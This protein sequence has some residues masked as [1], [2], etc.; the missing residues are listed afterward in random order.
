MLG[1]VAGRVA[2]ALAGAETWATQRPRS[3]WV[4]ALGLV[5]LLV[6]LETAYWPLHDF[7]GAFW[8][9]EDRGLDIELG[10][11]H[12]ATAGWKELVGFWRGRMLHGHGYFRPLSSW[13]FVAEYRLF[14]VQDRFWTTFSILFH[15]SVALLL[16]WAVAGMV[17]GSRLRRLSVGVLA[18]LL[19]G[20]PGC[21]DRGVQSWVIGWWPAQPE[22]L[23]LLFG[24]LVLGATA[25]FV[26]TGAAG[27]AW[28]AP[29]A[30]FLAVTSKEM[31]YVAGLGACLLLLRHPRRWGLLAALSGLGI[32]LFLYRNAVLGDIAYH[33]NGFVRERLLGQP[34]ELARG[35]LMDL[36]RA[37]PHLAL[38]APALGVGLALRRRQPWE[39]ALL[40]AAAYL[41]PASLL[42][43]P[44]T[45]SL[46]QSGFS[47]LIE[48]LLSV[49]MLAALAR[50]LRE[51][52][53]AELAGLYVAAF[54]TTA[55]FPPTFPWYRYWWTVFGAVLT[56]LALF[57][58]GEWL[59]SRLPRRLT[60][61]FLPREQ[62]S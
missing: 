61:S 48:L 59:H 1:Q 4:A 51:W 28:V 22:A 62:E 54:A 15:L 13:L 56:A 10:Q 40:G 60:G 11:Q 20:A 43:G 25:R 8:H 49:V 42:L 38:L 53:T 47:R 24:L 37:W 21:A 14:G 36:E 52:P 58:A 57:S 7:P 19:F 16:V 50:K 35:V 31:G 26:R 2:G 45:D 12:A 17:G 32:A 6:G 33:A 46:F 39:C 3:A 5:L 27:W 30:F 41:L 29:A 44:P 23:S 55:G 18:A 9:N 34:R